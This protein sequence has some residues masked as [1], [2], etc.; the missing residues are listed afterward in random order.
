MRARSPVSSALE[1]RSAGDALYLRLRQQRYGSRERRRRQLRLPQSLRLEL[2]VAALDVP[3]GLRRQLH[4]VDPAV[5]TTGVFGDASH[6]NAALGEQLRRA[7]A[8][9]VAAVLRSIP[10]NLNE[11]LVANDVASQSVS[12]VRLCS[13]K[14]RKGGGSVPVVVLCRYEANVARISCW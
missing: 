5:P 1:S 8:E 4:D 7:S 10:S 9:A 12:G 6:V 3:G 11:A 13:S 14:D 2:R